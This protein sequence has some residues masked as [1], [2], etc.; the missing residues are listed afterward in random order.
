MSSHKNV[1]LSIGGTFTAVVRNILLTYHSVLIRVKI[2]EIV[3]E[4]NA[5]TLM[6]VLYSF[7][8][9]EKISGQ[10]SRKRKG[11]YVIIN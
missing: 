9:Q 1:A 7:L 3:G 5:F 10:I 6:V 8:D 4:T 2:W 11:I